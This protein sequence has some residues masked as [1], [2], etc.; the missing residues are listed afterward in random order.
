MRTLRKTLGAVVTGL[1]LVAAPVHADPIG[2]VKE[3][4]RTAGHAVPCA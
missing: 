1:V 3:S 2:V 4:G